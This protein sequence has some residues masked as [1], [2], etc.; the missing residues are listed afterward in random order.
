MLFCMHMQSTPRELT[1][2]LRARVSPEVKK[3]VVKLA[4]SR[5][6]DES[7]IVRAAVLQFITSNEVAQ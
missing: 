5:R 4:K 7:E 3:R 6:S 1:K 2:V